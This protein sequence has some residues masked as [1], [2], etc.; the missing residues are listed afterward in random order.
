MVS[1]LPQCER[2][3]QAEILDCLGR[4][5]NG[6]THARNK[7]II[8]VAPMAWNMASRMCRSDR[9]KAQESFGEVIVSLCVNLHKYNSKRSSF[10]TWAHW[11]MYNAITAYH[12]NFRGII[13]TPYKRTN[14]SKFYPD[15]IDSLNH[16]D[17]NEKECC[18]N[19]SIDPGEDIAD[20]EIRATQRDAC[21]I[22]LAALDERTRSIV[23]KRMQCISLEEIGRQYQISKERVRQIEKA[24]LALMRE[25]LENLFGS[26]VEYL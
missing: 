24:G 21:S 10:T 2:L 26:K 8:S 3:T 23:N 20:D 25:T 6:D 14:D 18:G 22:A 13:K 9:V 4:W 12:R 5:K 15:F 17:D 11:W 7:V 1:F 19:G 16:S